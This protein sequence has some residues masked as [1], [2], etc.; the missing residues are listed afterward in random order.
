[1]IG[2]GVIGGGV[3]VSVGS[4]NNNLG[5]G[6]GK[7]RGFLCFLDVDLSLNLRLLGVG[8]GVGSGV[9]SGVG[10]GL[11]PSTYC[12]LKSTTNF[13]PPNTFDATL[14]VILVARDLTALLRFLSA[15]ESSLFATMS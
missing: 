15:F 4:S 8:V 2:G 13:F 3:L 14:S 12:L 9:G 7:I 10:I 1:M 6:S 11:V 5:G